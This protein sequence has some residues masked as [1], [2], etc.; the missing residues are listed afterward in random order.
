MIKLIVK[1]LLIGI[2]L[3]CFFFTV[4][5]ILVDLFSDALMSDI[6][7]RPTVNALGITVICIGFWSGGIV[8]EIERLSFALKLVVHLTVG[9]GLLLIVMLG[10]GWISTDNIANVV[11]NVAVNAFILVSVWVV[12]YFRDKKE[13][14]EI[15]QLLSARDEKSA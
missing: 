5:V 9:I 11:F 13:V 15:N 2:G 12:S 14:R 10:L 8:Y 1:Y 3:G 4:N 6:L 7:D